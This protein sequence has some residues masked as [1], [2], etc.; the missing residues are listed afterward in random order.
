MILRLLW[1]FFFS[2]NPKMWFLR[3]T[4]TGQ[5]YPQGKQ[6]FLILVLANN[7]QD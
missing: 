2:N 5:I 7:L 1:I 3:G 4:Y 6:R